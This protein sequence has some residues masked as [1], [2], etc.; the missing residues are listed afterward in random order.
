MTRWIGGVLRFVFDAGL[1]D[2]RS[3]AGDHRVHFERLTNP[4]SNSAQPNS[5]VTLRDLLRESE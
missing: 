3:G 4:S 1:F 5:A 2:R